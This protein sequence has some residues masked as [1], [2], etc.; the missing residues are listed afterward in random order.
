[1]ESIRAWKYRIYPSKIQ[2]QELNNYLH[3]CKGLWNSL[4]EYTKTYYEKT[5]KF[6]KRTELHL[7]TKTSK[8]Y[9]QVAQN[10][11]DRLTKSLRGMIARKKKG[12]DAGFPRFKSIERMKSFTYPQSH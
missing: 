10:V 8:L 12:M 1:M 6:P 9:S 5:R 3:E 7:L 2:E 4:L 11:A